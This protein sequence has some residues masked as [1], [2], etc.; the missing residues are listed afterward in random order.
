MNL[1]GTITL[2]HGSGGRAMHQLVD[3]L[4]RSTFSNPLLEEGED[5]ARIPLA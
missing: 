2:A 3:D 5:Q 1:T 4:I